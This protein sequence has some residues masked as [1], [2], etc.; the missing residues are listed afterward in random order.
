MLLATTKLCGGW[1]EGGRL[2]PVAFLLATTK[3]CVCREGVGG[4][5]TGYFQK[6]HSYWQ[7][8]KA[9]V[10][11]GEMSGGGGG[12]G[13]YFQE[14]HG[15]WKHQK[16]D[17]S[18]HSHTLYQ[19]FH[20]CQHTLAYSFQHQQMCMFT[21]FTSLIKTLLPLYLSPDKIYAL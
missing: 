11:G 5:G 1:V 2:L 3:L 6:L 19:D 17:K 20:C 13:G 15:Y 16:E 18:E 10:V 21:K 9:C 8:Q 4:G 12:G 7:Q 14:L